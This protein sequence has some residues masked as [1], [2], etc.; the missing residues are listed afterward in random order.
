VARFAALFGVAFFGAAFF[1]DFCGPRFAI[2]L[3]AAGID[4][5]AL[6]FFAL[7]FFALDFFAACL[8]LPPAFPRDFLA[9]V[10]MTLLPGVGG[11]QLYETIARTEH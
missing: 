7:D 8:A 1:A 9:R 5:L 6:D 10:A 4:F 3:F 2:P 11:E